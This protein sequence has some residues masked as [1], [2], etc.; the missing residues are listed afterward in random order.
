MLA[1]PSPEGGLTVKT[2]DLAR[3]GELA[4]AG[5]IPLHELRALASDLEDLFF[6]LTSA[7][8]HR[9]RN[10]GAA[11]TGAPPTGATPAG[12]SLTQDGGSI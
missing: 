11:P 3:V 9:N 2:H 7:P 4:F 1:E 12:A 5:G 6:R 8:E 10:L